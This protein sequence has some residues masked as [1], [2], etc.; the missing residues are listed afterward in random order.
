MDNV[1][2]KTVFF[3]RLY[4]YIV[5]LLPL[6]SHAGESGIYYY[7]SDYGDA[8]SENIAAIA[9]TRFIIGGNCAAFIDSGGRYTEGQHL[10]TALREI[11]D[12]PVLC[13]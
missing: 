11:T 2:L 7:Q 6:I 12:K 3:C 9:N 8:T 13:H 4:I 5:S 10:N 1:E